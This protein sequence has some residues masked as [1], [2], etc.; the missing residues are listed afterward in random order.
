MFIDSEESMERKERETEG[1]HLSLN[2]KIEEKD[3]EIMELTEKLNG[4]QLIIQSIS[5]K[6]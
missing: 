6:S 4:N 5:I 1:L 3:K 2:S